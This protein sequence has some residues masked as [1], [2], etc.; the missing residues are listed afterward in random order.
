MMTPQEMYSLLLP[1]VPD[2]DWEWEGACADTDDPDQFFPEY[3]TR[4]Q[5][6]AL[7]MKYCSQCPV[8]AECLTTGWYNEWGIWA[9]T[10]HGDRVEARRWKRKTVA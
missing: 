2:Y 3:P 10:R 8:R 4:S 7:E 9:G 1:K 5:A 6:A